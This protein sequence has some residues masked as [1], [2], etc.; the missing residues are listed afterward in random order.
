MPQAISSE[1]HEDYSDR[2]VVFLDLLGFK[3]EVERAEQNPAERQRLHD[4]LKLVRDTLC[5][6]P[7]IHMRLTCF[8]DCIIFSAERTANGL[9]E[10]FASVNSLTFNL[11]Q[12]NVLVRGGLTAG[13]AHHGKDFV[14]GTAVNRAYLLES[15]CA[16]API[17]LISSEVFNDAQ[18]YGEP[19]MEWIAEDAPE[20][21]F[22]HYLRQYAEYRHEPIYSGKVVL[23][24]PANR[25][26]DFVCQ[27]L[28]TDI[29]GVLVK[30][31]WLQSYW[32]RAVAS[33]GVLGTIEAGVQ[34]RY[35]SHGPTIVVRRIIAQP[36]QL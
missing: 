12:Y 6:N 8:S 28:N 2:Y 25:I 5:E 3:A 20:R 15:E 10:I 30:A 4:I 11:L 29:G 27:R 19:F 18:A 26:I 36:S 35:L 7:S 21:Y 14:Y 24:D 33:Q 34:Q 9:W 17:T 13:G 31:E 22:V 16:K 32:N 23:D 1:S